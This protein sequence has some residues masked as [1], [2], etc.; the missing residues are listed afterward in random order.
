MAHFSVIVMTSEEPNSNLIDKFMAPYM[1]YD[2]EDDRFVQD[3]DITDDVR[4]QYESDVER[5]LQ[6]PDGSLHKPTDDRFYRD[7]TSDELEIIGPFGGTGGAGELRW[8]TQDWG[9]GRGYT[10]KV[11]YIPDGWNQIE[12]PRKDVM[13]FAEFIEYWHNFEEVKEWAQPDYKGAHGSGYYVTNAEEK[14]T[15][16]FRRYNPE[17]HWDWYVIGGRWAGELRALDTSIALACDEAG[18][19]EFDVCQR[20]NLDIEAMR[21]ARAAELRADIESI[22]TR[23]GVDL[24]TLE[25]MLHVNRE[26]HPKWLEMKPRPQGAEYGKWLCDAHPEGKTLLQVTKACFSLPSLKEGQTIEDY[27]N[28]AYPLT[29]HAVIKDGKWLHR[30]KM[31]MFTSISDETMSND[32]WNEYVWKMVETMPIDHWITIVDCHV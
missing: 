1:E 12:V 18:D 27:V 13:T 26:L 16:V 21:L 30:G 9:D 3:V 5:R 20:G 17:G 4:N 2:G 31:G 32:E 23:A 22:T 29:A 11:A 6:A 19:G 7:P 8:H 15:K 28:S 24:D 25:R 14:V 10:T